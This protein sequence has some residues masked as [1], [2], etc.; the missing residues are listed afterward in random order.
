[1]ET[2]AVQHEKLEE[3]IIPKGSYNGTDIE[4]FRRDIPAIGRVFQQ[5]LTHPGLDPGG[6]CLEWYYNMNDVRC[7]V[8][9]KDE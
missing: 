9:L 3:F 6:F 1:M 7:M 8:R 2:D 4:N 5:L